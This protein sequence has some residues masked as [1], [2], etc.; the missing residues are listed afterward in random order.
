MDKRFLF[1]LL[2]ACPGVAQAESTDYKVKCPAVVGEVGTGVRIPSEGL[3]CF[4]SDKAALLEGFTKKKG[5]CSRHR[6]VKSCDKRKKKYR[7]RDGTLSPTCKC[8]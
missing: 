2:V 3:E 5:C 7:C 6:G 8:R 1:F 4:A